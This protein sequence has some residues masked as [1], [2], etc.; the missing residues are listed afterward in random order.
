[1][2]ALPLFDVVLSS[3]QEPQ[4]SAKVAAELI[5]SALG[6]IRHVQ[7]LDESLAPQDPAHFDRQTVALLRGMYEDWARQ[8]EG[9][10][11]RIAPLER[12]CGPIEGAQALRDAHGRTR[13]MLSIPLDRLERAHK[14]AVEGRTSPVEEV[15]RELRLRIKSIGVYIRTA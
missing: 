1:M 8:A 10:L 6:E 13:A 12:R 5:Q 9:L 7:N 2:V 11:E 14:D 15:R 4:R 3:G